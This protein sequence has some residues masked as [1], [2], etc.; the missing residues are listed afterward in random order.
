MHCMYWLATTAPG[1]TQERKGVEKC[2]LGGHPR[3]QDE[4]APVVAEVR[5]LQA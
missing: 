5:D 1:D 4:G 3:E 2:A